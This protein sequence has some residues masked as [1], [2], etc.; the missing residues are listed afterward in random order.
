MEAILSE[1]IWRPAG[2]GDAAWRVGGDGRVSAYCCLYAT[3]RDWARV[4]RLLVGNGTPELP[5]LPDAVWRDW[6]LPDLPPEARRRSAYRG[7]LRHDVLDRAGA[8]IAGPFAY[9]MGH[10]G[11]VLYL[12]P[13]ADAVVVR[14]GD[15]PQLLHSTLYEVLGP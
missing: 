13:G 15:A 2:A 8:G 10:R 3:A 4:G 6:N 9:A 12:L 11:Q 5:L 7:H 1:V 14:F